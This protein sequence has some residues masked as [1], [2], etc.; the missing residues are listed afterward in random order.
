M[1]TVDA[2]V[3]GSGHNALITAVSLARAGWD[4]LVAE[5]NDEIGGATRSG[6]VTQ[7]GLV[8]D[9]Y[10]TNINLFLASPAFQEFGDDLA[11]H[12]FRPAVSERSY[13]NVFPDGRSLRVYSDV[14]RTERL[15]GEHSARD[16]AGWRGLHERYGMF[17]KALMPL[18]S[19]SLPS[20]RALA[21][22][23]KGVRAAG[24]FDTLELLRTL[25]ASTRELGDT[26][27]ETPEAKALIATWGMHL[28][29]GPDV[30]GGAM[31][32]FLET[33]TDMEQGIAVAEGGISRL[34]EALAALVREAGGEV[35]TGS[36]VTRVL[37]DGD[38]VTGVRLGD[39]EEIRVRRT[40]VAGTTPTQ[41]F[42]DL[43]RDDPAVSDTTRTRAE[44][45]RYG[46]G[47]MVVHLALDRPLQWQAEEEL[48]RFAYVHVAPYVD[49]LARTYQ[50]ALAG[51]L[52][53][54]PLL[55]VGQTSQVDPTRSPDDRQVVWVQV[56][57]LP[58]E[59]RG[60]AA[61]EITATH[62]DEAR[63]PVADRVLAKL[64]EYAP[65][66]RDSVLARTVLSPLDLERSNPNLV[67]GDSVSGSHHLWQNFFFRPWPGASTYEMPIEGLYLVGAATW[68]GGGTNGVSGSLCARRILEP[69]PYRRWVAGGA[70]AVAAGGAALARRSR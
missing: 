47:T 38:R 52:P 31:F 21:G 7:P 66:A 5:R 3:I 16:L 64:E 1:R 55:I 15:L 32:P 60:D 2:V 11:R 56:R 19:T 9:L 22:L 43:L 25:S 28:D 34:P 23:A 54:S 62:W 57:M 27:F 37:T 20:L 29:Y 26:W 50:Q 12:G 30:S 69:H 61:G 14:E 36:P 10:A 6:E 48:S 33:F 4:V 41:L 18:Y 39:G 59:I 67:G 24:V 49:D 70:A 51:Q 8:H 63:E 13:S 65:G 46:P 53:D 17:M 42:G 58:S 44:R 35:R 40:V 68:P 45:Y